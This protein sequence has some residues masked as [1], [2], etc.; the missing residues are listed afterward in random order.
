[1]SG[2]NTDSKNQE[3]KGPDEYVYVTGQR[4][5]DGATGTIAGL[6][7]GAA[8]GALANKQVN[9]I[10][11]KILDKL[12]IGDA[13]VESSKTLNMKND[14]RSWKFSVNSKYGRVGTAV[15]G[16][17]VLALVGAMVGDMVG[18]FRGKKKSK[19]ALAQFNEITSENREL[20]GKLSA[21]ETITAAQS[22]PE[23]SY[24][25]DLEKQRSQQAAQGASVA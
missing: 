11:D 13:A 1:M 6:A 8:G 2:N 20:K 9:G 10:I 25:A 18:Y 15:I 19:E 5:V 24:V 3:Y 21:M 17:A 16:A 14:G 4:T 7:V 12:N 22:K 23:K